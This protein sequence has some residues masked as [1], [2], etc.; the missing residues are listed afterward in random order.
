[1]SGGTGCIEGAYEPGEAH[2]EDIELEAD[3][4]FLDDAIE[5]FRGPRIQLDVESIDRFSLAS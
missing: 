3:A 5:S 1:M 4:F 2:A